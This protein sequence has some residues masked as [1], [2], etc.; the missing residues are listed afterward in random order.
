[1]LF[2]GSHR[3]VGEEPHAP[4]RARTRT[5]DKAECSAVSCRVLAHGMYSMSMY[6]QLV[7]VVQPRARE[8]SSSGGGTLAVCVRENR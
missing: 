8:A 4:T 6:R 3:V 7:L 2:G 1:M 5:R